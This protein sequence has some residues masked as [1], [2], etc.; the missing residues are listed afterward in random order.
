MKKLLILT[1][2]IS[3]MGCASTPTPFELGEKVSPPYGYS[4]LERRDNQ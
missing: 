1:I 4:D 3:L 2:L